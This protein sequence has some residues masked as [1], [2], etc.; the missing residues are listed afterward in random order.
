ML[1]P[2]K[3]AASRAGRPSRLHQRRK[4]RRVFRR[5]MRKRPIQNLQR[6]SPVGLIVKPRVRFGGE[7]P[8][9]PACLIRRQRTHG[10]LHTTTR[11]PK[12]VTGSDRDPGQP[13]LKRRLPREPRQTTIG[14]DEHVMRHL[15]GVVRG[16]VAA[17]NF[18]HML[19]MPGNQ[20]RKAVDF[21][22]QDLFD[23]SVSSDTSPCAPVM[24]MPVAGHCSSQHHILSR[25]N[26]RNRGSS[27]LQVAAARQRLQ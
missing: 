13:V 17:H 24:L 16:D 9:E 25:R 20:I 2:N 19:P 6:F 22:T 23:N 1:Q 5:Q 4:T 15:S 14:P 12:I 21:A 3:S 27:H 26:H 7:R 11:S 18:Q 8:I 10:N